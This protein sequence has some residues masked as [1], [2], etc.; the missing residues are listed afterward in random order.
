MA[1]GKRPTHNIKLFDPERE[2]DK[3]KFVG[4]G[5]RL[6]GG[7]IALKLD[8]GI[9]LTTVGARVVVFERKPTDESPGASYG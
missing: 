7:G 2:N 6:K 9:I 1:G 3:G 4:V 5:W 8:P